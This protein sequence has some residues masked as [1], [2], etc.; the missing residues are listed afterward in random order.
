[1]LR[2]LRIYGACVRFSF[3]RAL[4]F[5]LDFFFKVGMDVVWLIVNLVFFDVLQRHTPLLGGWDR[6]QVRVF[7]AGLFVVDAAHM[8]IFSSN[9]WW[10]PTYVNRGD[11]DY[12]LLRPV[13][14][15]FFLMMREFAWNSFLNLLISVGVLVWALGGLE[16]LPDGLHLALYATSL[17]LGV[18]LQIGRAHV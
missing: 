15:L 9:V 18:L 2:Y 7:A 17:G 8:T 1:M 11:L 5:R 6:S 3:S 12:H 4:E 13:S 10:F 16:R 14:S